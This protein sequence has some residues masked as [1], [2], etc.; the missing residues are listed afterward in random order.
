MRDYF[1]CWRD[2][3]MITPGGIS[4]SDWIISNGIIAWEGEEEEEAAEFKQ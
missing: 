4:S 3:E 2:H 1:S